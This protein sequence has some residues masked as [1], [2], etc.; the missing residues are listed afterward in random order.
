[1]S[2][3]RCFCQWKTVSQP[4][5]NL[6]HMKKQLLQHRAKQQDWEGPLCVGRWDWPP[7]QTLRYPRVK[8]FFKRT[9][10]VLGTLYLPMYFRTTYVLKLTTLY[11]IMLLKPPLGVIWTTIASEN[12][13]HRPGPLCVRLCKNQ[14]A[15]APKG[16]QQDS[17]W[18]CSLQV[19]L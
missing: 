11:R 3:K 8:M 7:L 5:S 9:T 15:S 17:K 13:S 2:R 16:L 12:C 19:L 10:Y 1:M 18:H 14:P 6:L 4:I